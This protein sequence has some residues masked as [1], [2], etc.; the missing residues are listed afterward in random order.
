MTT[1]KEFIK[2]AHNLTNEEA[3][4]IISTLMKVKQNRQADARLAQTM[5]RAGEDNGNNAVLVAEAEHIRAMRQTLADAEID[6]FVFKEGQLVDQDIKNYEAYMVARPGELHKSGTEGALFSV[7]GR[8]KAYKNTVKG[9]IDKEL[10]ATIPNVKKLFDN[11]EFGNDVAEE[12]FNISGGKSRTGNDYA[13]QMAKIF[14]KWKNFLIDEANQFG[15]GIRKLEGHINHQRHN[16]GKMVKDKFEKWAKFTRPFLDPDRTFKGADE[17][18]FLRKA[19]NTITAGRR[20]LEKEAAGGSASLAEKMSRERVLHFKD[21]DSWVQYNARYGEETIIYGILRDFDR[22]AENVALMKAMGPDPDGSH[23]RRMAKIA[24]KS[25]SQGKGPLGRKEALLNNRFEALTYKD[26]ISADL[27]I[28][29]IGD[30]LRTTQNVSK[31]GFSM[32]SSV[33]D[34][35]TVGAQAA[36]MGASR[37]GAQFQIINTI[38]VM[39]GSRRKQIAAQLGVA[40]DGLMGAINNRYSATDMLPGTMAKLNNIFFKWSGLTWWTEAWQEGFAM[41]AS[42]HIADN[43]KHKWG[44][45]PS[46]LRNVFREYGIGEADWKNMR[47]VGATEIEGRNYFTPDSVKGIKGGDQLEERLRTLFVSE[48]DSAVPTPGARERSKLVQGTQ[49]GTWIGEAVRLFAQ[50]KMFPV[51]F[52]TKHLGRSITFGKYYIPKF[53][54]YGGLGSAALMAEMVALGLLSGSLKDMLK[55][56][57]P[58]PLNDPRT[59]VAAMVQGGGLGIY[60]DI[61]FQDFSGYGGGFVKAL[62]GPT[63]GQIDTVMEVWSQMWRGGDAGATAFRGIM[64]NAPFANLF[65]T[66]QALDY[67]LVWHIQEMLNPGFVRRMEQRMKRDFGQDPLFARP[68]NVIQTGGGFK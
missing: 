14:N 36:R 21:A 30:L 33:N 50:F 53:G 16:A 20:S 22:S 24:D 19:F 64:N 17:E 44:Q 62:S 65:Y 43:L 26:R 29:Y 5:K 28:A 7:D 63:F 67:L 2:G 6:S 42:T 15:A 25:Q 1:C 41:M 39:K 18:Q 52:G 10:E 46:K 49:K 68:S 34:V 56:K 27:T 66:K 58:K 4:E 11:K 31:L 57:T 40:V 13:F 48:A 51:T 54:E 23:T 37:T 47:R 55:G 60:G 45:M 8:M 38:A 61:L 12:L 3:D 35:A 9:K 32:I 59:W